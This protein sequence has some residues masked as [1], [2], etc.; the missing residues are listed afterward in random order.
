MNSRLVLCALGMLCDLLAH[1]KTF[2]PNGFFNISA[3]RPNPVRT[4][5][6]HTCNLMSRSCFAIFFIIFCSFSRPKTAPA[7]SVIIFPRVP[8]TILIL[9]KTFKNQWF[10]NISAFWP[11]QARTYM[12]H[13]CHLM[14]RGSFF[15]LS[16]S[17]SS[18]F[19]PKNHSGSLSC[20]FG[21][22]RR[23]ILDPSTK[24]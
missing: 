24:H 19:S 2:K 6:H 3:S 22:G 5:I 12:H 20:S 15:L 10:F 8:V 1:P 16:A 9:Q 13:A 23:A 21:W 11:H 14:S 18:C 7:H 17:F 4:H